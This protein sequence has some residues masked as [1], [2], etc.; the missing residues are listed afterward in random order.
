MYLSQAVHSTAPDAVS[1]GRY[2]MPLWDSFTGCQRSA[3]RGWFH[4]LSS[5]VGLVFG[6][7]LSRGAADILGKGILFISVSGALASQAPTTKCQSYPLPHDHFPML[8]GLK[9]TAG[10]RRT[11]SSAGPVP[12]SKAMQSA[13]LRSPW[14]TSLWATQAWSASL[15]GMAGKRFLSG[16]P[17]LCCAAPWQ[18]LRRVISKS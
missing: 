15:G 1:W 5:G 3:G 6:P 18:S 4:S 12:R 16:G 17:L 11:R 9:T 7:L 8:S 13:P 10:V 14:M 2:W